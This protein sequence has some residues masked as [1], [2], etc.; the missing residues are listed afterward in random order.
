MSIGSENYN[1]DM[2]PPPLYKTF[3]YTGTG[4]V[5]KRR[6]R[7]D[8]ARAVTVAE[9]EAQLAV[10]PSDLAHLIAYATAEPE[11]LSVRADPPGTPVSFAFTRQRR[12]FRAWFA[13]PRCRGRAAKLFCLMLGPKEVWG[14]GRCLGLVYPTQAEH[15][16]RLRDRAIVEGGLAASR[17]ERR[18]AEERERRRWQVTLRGL[19]RRM[20]F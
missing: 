4:R 8:E 9:A 20:R 18:G 6:W 13:C 2:K 5:F 1:T 11:G 16:T 10:P 19:E 17:S 14:C 7:T 3:Y 12:G 15:K